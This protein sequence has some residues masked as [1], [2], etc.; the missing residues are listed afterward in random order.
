MPKTAYISRKYIESALKSA[1]EHARPGEDAP[2]TFEQGLQ[3]GY[4]QALLMACTILN[5]VEDAPRR[6]QAILLHIPG[7]REQPILPGYVSR[8][9]LDAQLA[10]ALSTNSRKVIP[11]DANL[12]VSIGLT[13]GYA[14]GLRAARKMLQDLDDEPRQFAL[15]PWA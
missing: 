6:S 11:T 15:S 14:D 1:A 2:R 13:L 8:E 4:E 10:A 3:K 5:T 7:T 9:K 12:A